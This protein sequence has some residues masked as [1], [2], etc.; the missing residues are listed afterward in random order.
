M[1]ES[2][3]DLDDA[4]VTLD[5]LEVNNQRVLLRVG[6]V[7]PPRLCPRRPIGD[8]RCL[9]RRLTGD[10]AERREHIVSPRV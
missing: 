8:D 2:R 4:L 10:R 6:V 1:T 5:D 7:Q 9:Q 3:S